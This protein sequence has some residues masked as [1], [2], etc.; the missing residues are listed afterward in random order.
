MFAIGLLL[1]LVSYIF[2][3]LCTQLFSGLYPTYTDINY[4]GRLDAT[5][6]SLF[7][8][9]TLDN[10]AD[11]ARTTMVAYPYA[12]LPIVVFVIVTGFV[13]VNLII[14]VIC[15]AISALHDDDKAKLHGNYTEDGGGDSG[16]FQKKNNKKKKNSPKNRTAT[17]NASTEE[18]DNDDAAVVEGDG[19]DTSSSSDQHPALREDVR[20]QLRALE[21]HVEE[22]TRA[23]EETLRALQELT[24]RLA[25]RRSRRRQ[26]QH[27]QRR[28]SHHRQTTPRGV[29][30]G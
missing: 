21:L 30:A 26:Q 7:Q 20:D 12:W 23:Q 28:K 1:F 24:S 3:V 5:F 19:D 14:A 18:E 25:E 17:T 6:F 8:I 16:T 13:V 27:Q 22:L 29:A 10:W 2:A 15:D 9:M 4:W 11:I